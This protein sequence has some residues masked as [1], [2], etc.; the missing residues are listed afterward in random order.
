MSEPTYIRQVHQDPDRHRDWFDSCA[1]DMKVEGVSFARY[2]VHPQDEQ[3]ALVEGWQ[4]K[5]VPDQG[6]PRWSFAA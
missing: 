1:A 4:E 5:V 6:E 3:L 2:S